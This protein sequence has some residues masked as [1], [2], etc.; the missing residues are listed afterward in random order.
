MP[1]AVILT[2]GRVACAGA[3]LA[4]SGCTVLQPAPDRG[5]LALETARAAVA[6]VLM[7]K[8]PGVPTERAV[9]CTLEYATR[10]QIEAL[11]QNSALGQPGL[12]DDIVTDILYTQGT[13]DCMRGGL[14]YEVLNFQ[15]F[16]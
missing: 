3:F 12:N 16:P 6:P 15:L 10:G 1:G 11:A 8:A 5:D 7:E 9:D 13:R 4:L 14:I 2:A